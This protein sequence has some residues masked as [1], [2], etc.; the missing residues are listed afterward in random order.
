[1]AVSG[2]AD[3]PSYLR[4]KSF[5]P[6]LIGAEQLAQHQI[7]SISLPWG[8]SVG[9]IFLSIPMY[10]APPIWK[11]I[12]PVSNT[13][14]TVFPQP[15]GGLGGSAKALNGSTAI[16]GP[17]GASGIGVGG[18]G[19]SVEADGAGSVAVGG[20][21]GAGPSADGS[22]GRGGRSGAEIFY[23]KMGQPIPAYLAGY[24]RGGV[25]G[26][27]GIKG[28]GAKITGILVEGFETGIDA[29]GSEINGAVVRRHQGGGNFTTNGKYTSLSNQ[30]LK[31]LAQSEAAKLREM[32]DGNDANND[33]FAR[34]WPDL[35]S[36]CGEIIR[37]VG[38]VPLNHPDRAYY[39]GNTMLS[40]NPAGAFVYTNCA[41]FLE[42][43]AEKL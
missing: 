24:G 37:R 40:G 42:R 1:M 10:F 6:F 12:F 34:I 5:V 20:E 8:I 15:R 13:A 32:G 43:I 14:P 16:G 17:G 28:P 41:V 18:D 27:T 25:G 21:G 19:G 22:G 11:R 33:L 23:E 38:F 3:F 26:S 7:T 29:P 31:D 4:D 36:L 9:L 39:G 2:D 30:D 35:H